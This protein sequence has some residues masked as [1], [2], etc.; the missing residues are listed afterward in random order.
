MLTEKQKGVV[1]GVV[2]AQ[3]LTI[4]GLAVAIYT[5][6]AMLL[7]VTPLANLKWDVLLALCLLGNIG[8]I[9]NHRFATPEDIDGG[10]LTT[11]SAQIKIYQATLQNTLEQVALAA[12]THLLWALSM[13]QSWQG[14][15]VW[16][17]ISF[18]VGRVFFWRGYASGAPGRAFGFGMTFYPTLWMLVMITLRLL[19]GGFGL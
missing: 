9:A 3:L 5:A 14:A 4:S 16:A 19:A 8:K 11:G 18:A 1:R 13:P 12:L 7:P 10:G 15:I 17:S 2:P 6:P